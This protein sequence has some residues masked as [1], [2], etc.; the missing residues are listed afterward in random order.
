MTSID[1]CTECPAGYYCQDRGLSEPTG[2]CKAGHICYGGALA[3]DP[4]YN[5]DPSGNQTIIT[6]GDTCHEGYYC[7]EGTALMIPCPRG[8]YNPDRSGQSEAAA[9]KPCDPGKYCNS[10]AL[11]DTTGNCDPGYYC[12]GGAYISDPKLKGVLSAQAGDHGLPPSMASVF[13][14]AGVTR[15]YFNGGYFP[16][17]GGGAIPKAFVRALKRAGGEI[18]LQTPVKRILLEG[19]RA[20]GVETADGEL[21]TADV[22]IS[23][24]DPEVTFGKLIGRENLPDKLRKKVDRV[25]Y[26][27][28]CLSLF[29]AVDMDLK[30]AGLD[31]GNNWFYENEDVD[32]L[33][34]MGLTDEVLKLPEPPAFFLTV[35][36][37]KDPTKMHKGHHTL[38]MFS[39]VGYDAFE[40]WAGARPG[41]R[42]D[43]YEAM[44]E[45]M[46]ERMFRALEKRIPGI[47]Q[48]VVF[49]N[50]GTPLTNEFYINATRG[51]LY[52]TDKTPDQVGPGGFNI[53]TPFDGLLMCGASTLSHG[54]SGVTATGL[55][56]ARKVLNART[57][58]LLT[59]NG[60]PLR[61]YPSEDMSLW[62]EE[63]Q[64]RA[65]RGA[66]K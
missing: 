34:K 25:K 23:N 2:M 8:T 52:G 46:A 5:N 17:G 11:T 43:D 32:G 21:I 58:E 56:A 64:Q 44:K 48:H 12:L 40:R 54:I 18:R 7:P 45:E 51:N 53:T 36:T 42:P 66:Q 59:Q 39:F 55:A 15:H 33:Y 60:P 65:K 31:S 50:L 14:H 30:A 4:V 16:R 57:S 26:S 28:S 13:M 27:T 38:E 19:K 41:A 1:N 6:W 3:D 10:T 37:L 35:T 20:V 47:S 22:I 49:W 62:P 24:A 29:F 63:L 9:C 61:I